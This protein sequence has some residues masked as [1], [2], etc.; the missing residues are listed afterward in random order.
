MWGESTVRTIQSGGGAAAASAAAC[1]KRAVS[2]LIPPSACTVVAAGGLKGGD[3]ADVGGPVGWMEVDVDV[4]VERMCALMGRR[5][6]EERPP[7][8]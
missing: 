6:W 2:A 8:L 5:L 7:F 3:A 4:D 1:W